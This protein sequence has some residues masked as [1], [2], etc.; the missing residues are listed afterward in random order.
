MIFTKKEAPDMVKAL[1]EA[2]V[3][4]GTLKCARIGDEQF[5]KKEG[6]CWEKQ[7]GQPDDI[8]KATILFASEAFELVEYVDGGSAPWWGKTRDGRAEHGWYFL[9]HDG[10]SA[11]QY[12][13]NGAFAS[14]YESALATMKEGVK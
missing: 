5:V 8:E 9:R 10:E 14:E 7:D 1:N 4:K 3:I 12:A 2:A 11:N 13:W 6:S